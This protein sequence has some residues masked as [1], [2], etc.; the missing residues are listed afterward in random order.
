MMRVLE[1]AVDAYNIEVADNATIVQVSSVCGLLMFDLLLSRPDLA[2]AI[3]SFATRIASSMR[4]D[5]SMMLSGALQ[6]LQGCL[7]DL[8]TGSSVDLHACLE[9]MLVQKDARIIG[10][11][12]QLTA[13][14]LEGNCERKP[15][16]LGDFVRIN[17]GAVMLPKFSQTGVMLLDT[18]D[19]PDD[20]EPDEQPEVEE[21]E[22]IF[23]PE[24]ILAH[25]DTK[26]K[27]LTK[28]RKRANMLCCL[29]NVSRENGCDL[30]GIQS[31]AITA[32][33]E[34]EV[35]NLLNP[36]VQA[37]SEAALIVKE[38]IRSLQDDG[39]AFVD[40]KA[41]GPAKKPMAKLLSGRLMKVSSQLTSLHTQIMDMK[42]QSL[43]LDERIKRQD[44][45][46]QHDVIQKVD[47]LTSTMQ[48]ALSYLQTDE[49]QGRI[50]CG[51]KDSRRVSFNISKPSMS[52]QGEEQRRD[53]LRM[54][55][56]EQMKAEN[57]QLKKEL[58]EALSLKQNERSALE[59][60]ERYKE[61]V[62]RVTADNMVFLM[63]L[64]QSE[65]ALQIA[66]EQ[67]RNLAKQL[68]IGRLKFLE[69]VSSEIEDTVIT[70][71][72]KAEAFEKELHLL[73]KNHELKTRECQEKVQEARENLHQTKNLKE[74]LVELE[75]ERSH[76]L[77]RLESET[78][79]KDDA[80]AEVHTLYNDVKAL[81]GQLELVTGVIVAEVN[82]SRKAAEVVR[83]AAEVVH[84][85]AELSKMKADHM[86]EVKEIQEKMK[87]LELKEQEVDQLLLTLDK[88]SA[89][90]E[91]QQAMN[92][93]LM[94]KKE[95]VEWLY[96][97]AR[98]EKEN[99]Q[100]QCSKMIQN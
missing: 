21:N 88:M 72:S 46:T 91:T 93:I 66:Q 47:D 63:K 70:S 4:T 52:C 95:E 98:A 30:F 73:Q 94:K 18:G 80:R 62:A 58:E 64:K 17:F 15:L 14:D 8:H 35:G 25:K 84:R 87:Q 65:H 23:V 83:E 1:D 2:V 38:V 33:D 53:A 55:D 50:V 9:P 20:G 61:V 37:T 34:T 79:E 82:A 68:E 60:V 51:S 10:I 24:Q 92:V 12:A 54:Q 40:K 78:R 49:G 22:Q 16:V 77:S 69:E 19:V 36:K 85:A 57:E 71:L 76:I 48:K 7:R 74:R 81:N 28:T 27:G 99:L 90:L 42:H 39:L 97:E 6:T 5:A 59:Q 31:K 45:S 29:G 26:N 75:E 32:N 3:G 11:C 96:L 67:Q 89:Q 44:D 100:R 41:F 13:G 86:A 56:G 43:L